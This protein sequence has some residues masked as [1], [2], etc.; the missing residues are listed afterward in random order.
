MTFFG[1]CLLGGGTVINGMLYYPP[2]GMHPITRPTAIPH[3]PL[4]RF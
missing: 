3:Y 2:P 1:G 4:Y